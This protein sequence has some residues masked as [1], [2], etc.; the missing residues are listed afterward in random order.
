MQ[1]ESYVCLS[2]KSETMLSL[3]HEARGKLLDARFA[4]LG[5]QESLSCQG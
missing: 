3:V 4:L 1:E 5:L 2:L